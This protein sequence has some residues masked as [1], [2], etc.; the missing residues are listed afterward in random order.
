MSEQTTSTEKLDREAVAERLTNLADELRSG[1][2]TTVRV[3]NKDVA[4]TPSDTLDY[5]IDVIEKRSRFRGNRE[6]VKIE[7]DWKA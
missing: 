3:G 6:T 4:L 1:E 2:D 7:I 5:K